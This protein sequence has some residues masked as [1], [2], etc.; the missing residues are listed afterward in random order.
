MNNVKET[1]YTIGYAL[2]QQED[3]LEHPLKYQINC[4]IDIRTL[5]YSGYQAHFNKE[6]IK[7]YLNSHGITYLHMD[8]AFGIIKDDDTLIGESGYVDFK[9]LAKRPLFLEGVER[10]KK[11]LAKGYVIAFLC[12]EKD[13]INCHR[14]T[15][16]ARAFY[17]RGYDVEHILYDGR[18]ESQKALEERMKE[19]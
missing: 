6:I 9:K 14:S 7:A 16:V 18:L 1:L 2:R 19:G 3:L 5:P 17:E 10:I 13:P 11:G 15:L 4:V 12:A 8:Q